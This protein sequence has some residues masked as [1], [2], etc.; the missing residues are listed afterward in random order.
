MSLFAGTRLGPYKTLSALSAAG[1]TGEVYRTRDPK[2]GRGVALGIL[3]ERFA[4]DPDRAARLTREAQGARRIQSSAYRPIYGSEESGPPP[5][6]V[7]QLDTTHSLA[8]YRSNS[9]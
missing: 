5:P 3:L 4:S 6:L 7:L 1:G 2:L 8:R 9:E